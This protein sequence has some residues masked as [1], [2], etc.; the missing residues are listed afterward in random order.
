VD[1]ALGYKKLS[2]KHISIVVMKLTWVFRFSSYALSVIEWP[3]ICK[4]FR[5]TLPTHVR[6][7]GSNWSIGQRRRFTNHNVLLFQI[8]ETSWICR[9]WIFTWR[10]S[11]RCRT[12]AILC[13]R[14]WELRTKPLVIR[15]AFCIAS[16]KWEASRPQVSQKSIS[17]DENEVGRCHYNT[18]IG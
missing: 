16:H 3:E 6:P 13:C 8:S 4:V 14:V 5:S 15:T 11:A 1:M 17:G 10:F 2:R 18:T 9:L 12:L 7:R